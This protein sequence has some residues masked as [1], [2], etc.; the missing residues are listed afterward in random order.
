MRNTTINREIIRRIAN[1]LGELN[2]EVMYVGGAVVSLYIND[3]AAE[4]IRPTKDIDISVS[5]ATL[6]ELEAL[7]QRLTSKGFIQSAEDSVICRF[8]FQGILL[9][10]MNTIE[11]GWAPANRWFGPGYAARVQVEIDGSPIYLMPLP[12]F[13][14][15]K[16]AAY[17]SRGGQ[18]PRTS[19]DMEDIVYILDNQMDIITEIRESPQDVKPFLIGEL[20][21]LIDDPLYQ[22]AVQAHLFFESRAI[23]YQ[24]IQESIR[25]ILDDFM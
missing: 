3:P 4:D 19:Q 7:R 8:R 18:D 25:S 13:L 23:R 20:Q 21:N 15:S 11:I 17:R 6:G 10:V 14:A 2:N 9:D 22:E 1:G 12:Y 5:V 16:F 24:R